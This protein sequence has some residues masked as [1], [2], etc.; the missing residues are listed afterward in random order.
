MPFTDNSLTHHGV[1]Q[2]S[3][4]EIVRLGNLSE[5]ELVQSMESWLNQYK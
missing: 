3:N 4:N 1:T 2:S 5:T